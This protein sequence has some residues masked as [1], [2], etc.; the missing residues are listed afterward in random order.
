[1][2]VSLIAYRL[3]TS[4]I[5]RQRL[6][7]AMSIFVLF[8]G[9]G[10]FFEVA[11]YPERARLALLLYGLEAGIALTAVAAGQVRRWHSWS[12]WVAVGVGVGELACVCAYHAM[13]GAQAERVA[14]VL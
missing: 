9:I 6:A 12:E 14:T 1:M 13:V 11:Y 5:L 7:V 2:R 3:E 10:T 4:A 8:M